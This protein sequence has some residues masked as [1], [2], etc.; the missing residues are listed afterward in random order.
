MASGKLEKKFYMFL[1]PKE[2]AELAGARSRLQVERLLV[3]KMPL[4]ALPKKHSLEVYLMDTTTTDDL[5]SS[6]NEIHGIARE[7]LQLRTS[8][9]MREKAAKLQALTAVAE[10]LTI[11]I[12]RDNA[13][14]RKRIEELEM[15]LK[16]LQ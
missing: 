14:L 16:R 1:T 15:E 11:Q 3:C 7:I 2:I 6:F 13:E 9:K 8:P 10:Q 5:I 4:H 12:R